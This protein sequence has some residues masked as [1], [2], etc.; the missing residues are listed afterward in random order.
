MTNE[1]SEVMEPK[2]AN[3]TNR[4]FDLKADQSV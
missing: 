2:F 4:R 1:P 3:P